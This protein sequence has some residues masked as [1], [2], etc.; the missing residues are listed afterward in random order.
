M[1]MIYP[2]NLLVFYADNESPAGVWVYWDNRSVLHCGRADNRVKAEEYAQTYGFTGQTVCRKC[3]ATI[4][5]AHY[6]N[7]ATDKPICLACVGIKKAPAVA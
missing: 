3:E 7:M 2:S 5:G 6:R 1:R 4:R